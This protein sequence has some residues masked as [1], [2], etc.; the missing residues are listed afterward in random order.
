M[1]FS[2][3]LAGIGFLLPLGRKRPVPAFFLE[4]PLRLFHTDP[5]CPPNERQRAQPDGEKML[6]RYRIL[7]LL[8]CM[9]PALFIGR[10]ALGG[11]VEVVIEEDFEGG[12]PGDVGVV[13]QGNG[14]IE[15]IDDGSGGN[16]VLSLT[17]A[18][19]N[20]GA[21]AWFPQEFE[22]GER[23][24]EPMALPSFSSST[25]T[26]RPS[27][28]S[29]ETL[30]SATFGAR[31]AATNTSRSALTSG[32]TAKVTGRPTVTAATGR[33]RPAMSRLSRTRP[34]HTLPYP[35][36]SATRLISSRARPSTAH[37]T[38]PPTP[39]MR[40]STRTI[41]SISRSSLTPESCECEWLAGGPTCPAG[42]ANSSRR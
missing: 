17:Q 42:A 33:R 38:S 39:A 31:E 19:G 12:L 7:S 36:P 18:E 22:L 41:S 21:W 1:T 35:R 10:P 20:Q 40:P 26:R 6:Y 5:A 2:G 25:T 4:Y 27:A 9:L 15:V 30:A 16:Q 37:R 13:S 34:L 23:R 32:T 11:D 24:V 3:Q 14:R 29:V 28:I 8:A